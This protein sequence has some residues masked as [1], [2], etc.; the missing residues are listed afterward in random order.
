MWPRRRRLVKA[1]GHLAGEA[2]RGAVPGAGARVSGCKCPSPQRTVVSTHVDTSNRTQGGAGPL[3][4]HREAALVSL[5][6]CTCRE[7]LASSPR[8]RGSRGPSGTPVIRETGR[9]CEVENLGLTKPRKVLEEEAV[10]PS[11]MIRATIQ[12]GPL[13]VGSGRQEPEASARSPLQERVSVAVG[14]VQEPLM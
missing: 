5:L 7:P 13:G 14:Q 9:E 11:R 8:V 1:W 2:A 6:P 12:K 4:S 3:R 10:G